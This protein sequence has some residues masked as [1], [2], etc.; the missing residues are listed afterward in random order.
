MRFAGLLLAVSAALAWG[1]GAVLIKRAGDSFSSTTLL[2][3]QYTLGLVL[4]A[5]WITATS[6]VTGARAAIERHWAALLVIAVLQIAG[7]VFFLGAIE[8]AGPHSIP[9][10]VA[11]A[12]AAAYPALV[13][14]LSGPFLGE[15]LRWNHALGVALVVVGVVVAQVL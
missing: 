9:T 14:I 8:R 2:V 5:A 15:E 6:G 12:I 13:A 10:A 1:V 11:V 7:Y 3:F 4:M